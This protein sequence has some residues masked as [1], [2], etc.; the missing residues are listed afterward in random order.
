MKDKRILEGRET[1]MKVQRAGMTKERRE[2]V[3]HSANLHCEGKRRN[4]L[5]KKQPATISTS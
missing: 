3:N 1:E 2:T 5:I 4:A